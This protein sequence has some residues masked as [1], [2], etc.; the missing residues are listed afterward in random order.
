MVILDPVWLE[1]EQQADEQL[2]TAFFGSDY[3][4][5]AAVLSL[6]LILELC[7]SEETADIQII[8]PHLDRMQ[9]LRSLWNVEVG[10]NPSWT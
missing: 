6:Q 5:I 1:A 8:Q 9:N 10:L 2:L 4:I 7:R 3:F